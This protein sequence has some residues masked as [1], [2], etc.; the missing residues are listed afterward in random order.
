[1]SKP[2]ENKEIID[3]G[4]GGGLLSERLARLGGNVLGLDAN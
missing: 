4:C 3:I 2:L 1:M